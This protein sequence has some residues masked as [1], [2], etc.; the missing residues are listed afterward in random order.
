MDYQTSNFSETTFSVTGFC[1]DGYIDPTSTPIEVCEPPGFPGGCPATSTCNSTC[2]ACL[3]SGPGTSGTAGD[4]YVL[5]NIVFPNVYNGS[6][7]VANITIENKNMTAASDPI[8]EK[9]LITIRDSQGV[10][11]PIWNQ[12]PIDILSFGGVSKKTIQVTIQT[13]GVAP[14]LTPKTYTL[15]ATAG[16]SRHH[17]T[18]RRY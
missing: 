3:S 15:Y 7:I 17:S 12:Y 1:G 6:D 9:L 2:D 5:K 4:V 13:G 16:I 8:Q 18:H 14:F 11:D 10:L